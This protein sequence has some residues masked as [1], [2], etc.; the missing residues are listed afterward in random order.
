MTIACGPKTLVPF[1]SGSMRHVGSLGSGNY[2]AKRE[3]EVVF[4]ILRKY[5][6]WFERLVSLVLNCGKTVKC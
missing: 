3:P 2:H 5:T 1:L 6:N 4:L